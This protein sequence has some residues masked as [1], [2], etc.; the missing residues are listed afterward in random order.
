VMNV[1]RHHPDM[2]LKPEHFTLQRINWLPKSQNIRQIAEILNIG[3]D[4]MI[5]IDDNPVECAEVEA[6]LPDVFTIR[7]PQD[8]RTAA[9]AL[10]QMWAFDL[11]PATREDSRR[12]ELYQKETQ[13]GELKRRS[14]SFA[15]FIADLNL[16]I[17]I[18]PAVT[19][20]VPRI[21]QL[22]IR[23]NQFNAA[24][25][26]LTE[27]QVGVLLGDPS[28]AC[29]TVQVA[30]RFGDY[31]L[32]GVMIARQAGQTLTVQNI[33]LSCRA[34]GR[35]VEHRMLSHLGSF[36]VSSGLDIVECRCA[37][38][39]KNEPIRGFFRQVC[40][41]HG[42]DSET[43]ILY[44][45]PTVVAAS[46]AFNPDDAGQSHPVPKGRENE[47]GMKRTGIR[48]GENRALMLRIMNEMND[49][50]AIGT[51]VRAS[52]MGDAQRRQPETTLYELASITATEKKLVE[53]W[54]DVLAVQSVGI[55]ENFFDAGGASIQMPSVAFQIR[56]AL[57]VKISLVDLFQY[58]TIS[59]LA[60]HLSHP[61]TSDGDL[62]SMATK[63]RR[64]RA[65]VGTQQLPVMFERLKRH[66]GNA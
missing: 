10:G 35:G 47:G 33:I 28:I 30:D 4:S 23:T 56:R 37:K 62:D 18:A 5:F 17:R 64:Q 54:K 1:L 53:I 63:G 12:A 26:R 55:H 22:T 9:R 65:M 49:V 52:R 41:A 45:V 44:R 32:V 31:G 24:G 50:V 2:L 8:S 15:E 58:P 16:V 66:R 42:V 51:A 13:R 39:E 11:P 43:G 57:D 29:F 6:N 21:S 40:G 36:A 19:E 34:L 14:L 59:T 60:R 7:L 38:T 27:S 3:L 25:T 46:I 61:G 48:V 20:H